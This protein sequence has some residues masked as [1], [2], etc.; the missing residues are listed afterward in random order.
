VP[1]SR[2]TV[3]DG[4]LAVPPGLKLVHRPTPIKRLIV[5]VLLL[6]LARALVFV[7]ASLSVLQQYEKAVHVAG[8]MKRAM[9]HQ[10]AAQRDKRGEIV[11]GDSRSSGGGASP[12]EVVPK[13]ALDLMLVRCVAPQLHNLPALIEI[14]V[15]KDTT[16]VFRG[17][18]V[19]AIQEMDAFLSRRSGAVAKRA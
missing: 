13:P 6:V 1:N 5:G 14:G 3:N 18:L 4:V 8:A 10:A 15:D 2:P 9:A 11:A 12:R 17:P 7:V 16:V 19:S